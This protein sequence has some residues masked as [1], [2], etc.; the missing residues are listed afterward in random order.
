MKNNDILEKMKNKHEEYKED[1][2]QK[3]KEYKSKKLLTDI[4]Q[5]F[6]NKLYNI[7]SKD[8]WV[9]PQISLRSIIDTPN[10]KNTSKELYRYMDIVFFNQ[11]FKPLLA[12]ELHGQEHAK[13]IYTINRDLSNEQILND[14]NIP[15][16]TIWTDENDDFK[17]FSLINNILNRGNNE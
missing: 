6:F 1:F 13:D 2:Y 15:L 17:L 7:Y 8:Y 10:F 14:A 4:E 11:N 16:L 5:K 9:L 12:I 3:G